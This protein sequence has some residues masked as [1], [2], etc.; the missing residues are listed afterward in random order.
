MTQNE[1]AATAEISQAYLSKAEKGSVDLSGRRLVAVAQALSFP[2]SF[3][4]LP[5]DVSATTTACVF[6]RKRNSLPVTAE[7]RVRAIL[8]VTRLQVTALVSELLPPVAL[9]REAPSADGWLGPEELAI[10]TRQRLG[11]GSGPL[12]DLTAALEAAGVLVV[13]QDLGTRRLDAVGQWPVGE[14]PFFLVNTS[15]PGDRQRFTLA[16]EVGHAVMHTEPTPDQEPEA[17]RFAS[18]LL[19]PANDIRSELA[20]PTMGRL[21]QLKKRWRVSIAAL[22]RRARDVGAINDYRYKQLNIELSAAG[23]RTREPASFPPE[24][25]AHLSAILATLAQADGGVSSLAAKAH[26]IES[27]FVSL[28]LE[29]PNG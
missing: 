25:P 29:R 27:E 4:T 2:T 22:I 14:R 13:A 7:R 28:Y 24:R 18:E 1:L 17:D 20:D 12:P 19:M 5:Q 3:L 16:H 11:F 15:A 6:P 26:M 21:V 23:Y 8:D 9:H 10:D